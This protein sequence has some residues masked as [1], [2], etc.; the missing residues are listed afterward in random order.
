MKGGVLFQALVLL[1]LCT[2]ALAQRQCPS[3]PV[4]AAVEAF[5]QAAEGTQDP[6]PAQRD[7]LTSLASRRDAACSGD[8]VQFQ[9]MPGAFHAFDVDVDLQTILETLYH[10]DI[11]SNMIIPSSVRCT[12]WLEVAGENATEVPPLAPALSRPNAT[13][14]IRGV[15]Q[16]TNTPDL[17]TG[18]YYTYRQHRLLVL[19]NAAQGQPV[20]ISVAAQQDISEV[21]HKGRVIGDD[22]LWTYYY[23][24]EKGV[25]KTGLG[26]V[27]SHIF[28]GVSITL[29][30]QVPDSRRTRVTTM[31][32]LNAGWMGMNM[33]KPKHIQ[34]GLERFAAGLTRVLESPQFPAP[35]HLVQ[36][37]RWLERQPQQQLAQ[38]R[39]A[40]AQSRP[41]APFP[42]DCEELTMACDV[43]YARSMSHN[44]LVCAVGLEFMKWRLGL[45]SAPADEIC[46]QIF[47]PVLQNPKG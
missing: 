46:R 28:D 12:K 27:D 14:I 40:L 10:P 24:G 19:S 17:F 21:G 3:E 1:L 11:P 33:V 45:S 37:G 43:K 20:L 34:A 2:P 31:K 7:V 26:W 6:T 36:V 8:P 47:A 42:T 29:Y 38:W 25:N 5:V 30:S 35:D 4:M 13:R 15:E 22:T 44:S 39:T 23:S 41:E 9:G 32:W 16:E 18:S